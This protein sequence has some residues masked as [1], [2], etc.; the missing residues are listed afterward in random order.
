M[1][2]L[3]RFLTFLQEIREE[4]KHVSWP[5]REELMG[6]ALV[7]LVGVVLLATYISVWDFLL[8]KMAQA[9]LR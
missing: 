4:I 8:S 1:K 2:S 3:R 7:V 9:L 5:T 6:S